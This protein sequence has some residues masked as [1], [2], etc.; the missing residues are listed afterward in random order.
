[1]LFHYTILVKLVGT[2]E[3]SQYLHILSN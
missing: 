3:E 2:K 1:M